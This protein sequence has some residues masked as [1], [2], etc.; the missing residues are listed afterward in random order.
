MVNSITK[1]VEA[2]SSDVECIINL[3]KTCFSQAYEK[4]GRKF[5]EPF[6]KAA[7]VKAIKN[8]KTLVY[9]DELKKMAV[10]AWAKY[11]EDY[12]GNNFGEIVLLLVRPDFQNKGIGTQLVSRLIKEL[13]I[14]DIRI[15]VLE[16]NPAKKLYA[17]L[18]FKPFMQVMRQDS[19]TRE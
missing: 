7:I 1:F 5:N 17:R 6:V 8:D 14:N 18:G 11:N 3:H 4:T 16:I 13:G 19:D 2:K 9:R 10:F 15:S 12:F